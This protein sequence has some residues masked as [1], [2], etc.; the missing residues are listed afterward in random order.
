MPVVAPFFR[1]NNVT[2]SQVYVFIDFC[3]LL[4]N[5]SSARNRTPLVALRGP[6]QVLPTEL[7][8]EFVS[9]AT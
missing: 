1:Q 7:S 8:T 5:S 2:S 4:I 3:E 6:A 9:C